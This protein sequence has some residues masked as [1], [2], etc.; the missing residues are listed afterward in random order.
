MNNNDFDS[1][2]CVYAGPPIL[3]NRLMPPDPD[4]TTQLPPS[5]MM[6]Y[7]G[8]DAMNAIPRKICAT[9]GTVN[10]DRAKFCV[11]CGAPLFKDE[12][13]K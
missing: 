3:N 1:M 8:P 13:K 11:E 12:D 4:M 7:A 5:M 9:C 6:V 10:A 2:K